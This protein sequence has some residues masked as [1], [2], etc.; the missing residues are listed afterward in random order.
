[1]P[2]TKY[3]KSR[4]ARIQFDKGCAFVGAALLLKPHTKNESFNYVY[5]HLIC[6]GIELILKELLLVKSC[7]IYRPKERKFG[8]NI[9]KLSESAITEF[10]LNPLKKE[11]KE[12]L[13]L[14]SKLFFEHKLRYSSIQDI[15]ID[16]SSIAIDPAVRRLAAIIRLALRH[17]NRI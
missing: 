17:L 12:C 1:M 6:Q 16:P 15:F 13:E 8:H 5:M 7:D 10:N 3:G 14:L 4:I 11:M 9:L 2:I